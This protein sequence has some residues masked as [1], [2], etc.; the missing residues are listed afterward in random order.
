MAGTISS[1]NAGIANTNNLPRGPQ[2][3]VGPK[4]EPGPRGDP[5]PAGNTGPAGIPGERGL[6]GS[7]G[8]AGSQGPPGPAGKG[9]PSGGVPGQTIIKASDEDFDTTWGTPA[10]Q[11]TKN[12]IL[13]GENV[14]IQDRFQLI[15]Y[16]ELVIEGDGELTIGI[17]GEAVVL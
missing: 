10:A 11:L 12:Y 15:V 13:A 14:I 3:P 7:Q 4:G 16:G 2:G 1:N 9:I 5:G 8:P 6:P 17:G